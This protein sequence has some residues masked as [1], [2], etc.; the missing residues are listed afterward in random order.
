MNVLTDNEKCRIMV[1]VLDFLE[2][3]PDAVSRLEDFLRDGRF[4]YDV[5]DLAAMTGWS[6]SY[7]RQLCQTNKLPHIPGKAI[8]FVYRDVYEA[9]RKLQRGGGFKKRN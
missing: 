4:L 3:E 1:R 5:K 7:L 6:Q 9:V 8:K 2:S